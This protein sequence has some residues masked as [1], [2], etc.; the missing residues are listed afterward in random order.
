MNKETER[1]LV[2]LLGISILSK[3]SDL[4]SGAT[5]ALQQGGAKLY[6]VLHDDADHKQDLPGPRLKADAI[7]ALATNAGFPD[8]KLAAAIALGESLGYVGVKNITPREYS[9]G[10]WQIN[11]KVHPYSPADMRDPIK[12]AA[13]AFAIYSKNGW[14][15]WGAYTNGRYKQFRKG[16][17]AP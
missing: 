8:P 16:I 5:E 11:T 15:P 14:Q 3:L 17:L 1:A 10:L 2:V 6:D 7:L 4:F 13:A 9:V 12:N